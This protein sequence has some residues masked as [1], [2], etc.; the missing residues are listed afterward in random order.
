MPGLISAQLTRIA[1]SVSIVIMRVTL[2]G[3]GGDDNPD[4]SNKAVHYAA[5]AGLARPEGVSP[6]RKIDKTSAREKRDK[7]EGE[8]EREEAKSQ[9]KQQA[10]SETLGLSCCL[11]DRYNF[12]IAEILSR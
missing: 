7:K 5:I 9:R 6:K 8:K 10:K 4:S 3:E 11:S 1:E 2:R 12:Q